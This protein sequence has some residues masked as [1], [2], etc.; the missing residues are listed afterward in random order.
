MSSS[1]VPSSKILILGSG[2]FGL[3]TA[4][5]LARAGYSDVTILDMQ[6]TAGQGYA[7]DTID[8][9]SADLNK[10]IRFSYGAEIAY[11]RLAT[12]A[13]AIWDAWNDEI[14]AVP[15]DELPVGLRGERKLWWRAGMLRISGGDELDGF[16]MLTLENMEREGLRDRLYRSDDEVG[17]QSDGGL[18]LDIQY[19]MNIWLTF[20]RLT[21]NELKRAG[22]HTRSTHR[23]EQAVSEDTKQS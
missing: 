2:V 3:S 16:E 18:L 4:L 8:S 7:P 6:D 13:A 12:E 22:G 20:I 10:I 21:S 23:T 19:I 11:Q 15:E 9:A 14:A 17:S 1:L 5:W